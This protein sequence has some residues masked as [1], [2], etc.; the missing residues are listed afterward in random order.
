MVSAGFCHL[1]GEAVQ[2]MKGIKMRFPLATFLCGLG[3]LFTLVADKIAAHTHGGGHGC[4]GGHALAK[5]PAADSCCAVE[6][7]AGG[8]MAGRRLQGGSV[9][10]QTACAAAR[11][12]PCLS[13]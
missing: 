10:G 8:W 3:Y 6:V 9:A 11:R 7:L 4:G 2:Q 5:L 1:L 12:P 13:G